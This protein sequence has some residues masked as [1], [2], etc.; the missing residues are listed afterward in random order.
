MELGA[1]PPP[2][3]PVHARGT[4]HPSA[5]SRLSFW[6]KTTCTSKCFWPSVHHRQRFPISLISLTLIYFK[7]LHRKK[8]KKTKKNSTHELFLCRS[9][10][11]PHQ[12]EEMLVPNPASFGSSS[13]ST[14][15]QFIHQ[16]R[17]QLPTAALGAGERVQE[18]E[19]GP[20]RTPRSPLAP[21]GAARGWHSTA[22]TGTL[23]G[24]ENTT[25]LQQKLSF[26]FFLRSPPPTLLSK[27]TSTIKVESSSLCHRGKRNCRDLNAT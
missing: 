1:L 9:S 23:A 24:G 26:S 7:I 18:T 3:S 22:P 14:R 19:W 27:S 13:A 16:E 20:P 11:K 2:A 10:T 5:A 21:R 12:G 8:K 17:A 6:C 15:S 25:C 4:R